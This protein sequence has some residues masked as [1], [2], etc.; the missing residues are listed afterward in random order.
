MCSIPLCACV[1]LLLLRI[2]HGPNR[3]RAHDPY[4]S[5]RET[6]QRGHGG[7][8]LDG[9]SVRNSIMRFDT[10]PKMNSTQTKIQIHDHVPKNTPHKNTNT[11]IHPISNNN[12]HKHKHKRTNELAT[13][14]CCCCS[15]SSGGVDVVDAGVSFKFDGSTFAF[16]FAFAGHDDPDE[17]DDDSHY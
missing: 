4:T 17:D 9:W 3:W 6:G 8:P 5:P 11:T 1:L 10:V 13:C 7:L 15:D 14:C 16:A 2:E 12:K